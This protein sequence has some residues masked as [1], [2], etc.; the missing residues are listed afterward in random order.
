[1]TNSEQSPV[2]EV[3][4]QCM[5]VP[6]AVS[7]LGKKQY[8]YGVQGMIAKSHLHQSTCRRGAHIRAWKP[9]LLEQKG[10]LSSKLFRARQAELPSMSMSRSTDLLV[11]YTRPNGRS[12][13]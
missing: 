10:R 8:Q 1:M 11:L 5:G 13:A 4:W 12:S 7:L 2:K 6:D 3:L 9:L